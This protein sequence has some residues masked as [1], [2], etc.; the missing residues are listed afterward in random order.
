MASLGRR[1]G[2]PVGLVTPLGRSEMGARIFLNQVSGVV[3]RFYVKF[4]VVYSAIPVPGVLVPLIPFQRSRKL[5]AE[6]RNNHCLA[7]PANGHP[8]PV[9]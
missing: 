7:E 4:D 6:T 3:L 1:L 8:Q 9:T 5:A 2:R